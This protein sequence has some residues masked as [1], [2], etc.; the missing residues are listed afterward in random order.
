MNYL[1]GVWISFDK[2]CLQACV[3][4]MLCQD[5]V[6]KEACRLLHSKRKENY[7]ADRIFALNLNRRGLLSISIQSNIFF[8]RDSLWRCP[9]HCRNIKSN[10][11]VRL[12]LC[13]TR[14][15]LQ[16]EKPC[17]HSC[18]CVH[19]FL[20][21]IPLMKRGSLKA[22]FL[23]SSVLEKPPPEFTCTNYTNCCPRACSAN[24]NEMDNI[25]SITISFLPFKH[26]CLFFKNVTGMKLWD[27]DLYYT[28]TYTNGNTES[29]ICSGVHKLSTVQCF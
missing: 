21:W 26:I 13:G 27:S 6:E 11:T 19:W 29:S 10:F 9:C 14:Q 12:W 8:R 23:D 25:Y 16:A 22:V 15:P 1:S 28:V 24:R 20:S 7:V 5:K 17:S 4:L 3:K 18:V 2:I